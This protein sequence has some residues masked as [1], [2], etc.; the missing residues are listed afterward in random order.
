MVEWWARNCVNFGRNPVMRISFPTSVLDKEKT[1]LTTG[2]SIDT[3]PS[4]VLY[5]NSSLQCQKDTITLKASYEK[6][7][8]G[9]SFCHH[10]RLYAIHTN[11]EF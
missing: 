9:F 6:R 5:A 1:A 7:D 8:V 3:D 4:A 2:W 10:H 11:H